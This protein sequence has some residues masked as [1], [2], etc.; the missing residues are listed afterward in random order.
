MRGSRSAIRTTACPDGISTGAGFRYRAP[1]GPRVKGDVEPGRVGT[2][3]SPARR[4][5]WSPRP[6]FTGPP[7]PASG[8]PSSVRDGAVPSA[9]YPSGVHPGPTAIAA[10][11]TVDG[12]LRE[13]WS[14]QGREVF[15]AWILVLMAAAIAVLL[16]ASRQSDPSDLRLPQW[17]DP[18]VAGAPAWA[19]ALS[20]WRGGNSLPAW[21][22]TGNRSL[23]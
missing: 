2:P 17:Y 10:D 14:T 13:G 22:G 11:R 21:G 23:R 8:Q 16:L 19:D 18:P 6:P 4:C 12:T 9:Q 5:D 7:L 1:L 3:S 15:A 20:A